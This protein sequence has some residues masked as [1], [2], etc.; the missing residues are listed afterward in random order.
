[1]EGGAPAGKISVFEALAR[2]DGDS[3]RTPRI[4]GLP[5]DEAADE[6][7]NDSGGGEASAAPDRDVADPDPL[8]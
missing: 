1:M 4:P 6:I 8:A 3:I 7:L 5:Y 2:R